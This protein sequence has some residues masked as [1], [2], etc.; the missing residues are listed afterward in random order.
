MRVSGPRARG[1]AAGA[2]ADARP[3]LSSSYKAHF[4]WGHYEAAV[5]AA[6]DLPVET[7]ACASVTSAFLQASGGGGGGGAPA[8]A[9]AP[10]APPP[11]PPPHRSR[12]RS[13]P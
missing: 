12:S 3:S 8:P 11:P 6:L 13:R 9:G 5:V 1:A 10:P 2:G 4:R 7:Q